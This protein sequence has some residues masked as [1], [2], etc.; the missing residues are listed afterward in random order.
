[1]G[2]SKINLIT[3]II[4]FCSEN[5]CEFLFHFL[6]NLTLFFKEITL[7]KSKSFGWLSFFIYFYRVLLGVVF[8]LIIE[9]WNI[10]RSRNSVYHFFHLVGWLHL[11]P[12]Y[13]R[14][15]NSWSKSWVEIFFTMK[16]VWL[17]ILEKPSVVINYV[18]V[19]SCVILSILDDFWIDFEVLVLFILQVEI[20]AR[21]VILN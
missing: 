3:K 15:L 12:Q 18:V 14:T 10:L 13:S 19:P 6:A 8:V 16:L 20:P 4:S 11:C 9:D 17:L 1:M 7:F 5:F 2:R 21:D